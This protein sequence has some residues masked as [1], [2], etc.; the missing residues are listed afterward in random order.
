MYPSPLPIPSYYHHTFYF[1]KT[2]SPF[3]NWER[4]NLQWSKMLSILTEFRT[5]KNRSKSS[6]YWTLW[7][8]CSSISRWTLQSS[9]ERIRLKQHT[10]QL[11]F[12][13]IKFVYYRTLNITALLVWRHNPWI[14]RMTSGLLTLSP[15]SPGIPFIP[16]KPGYPC[17]KSESSNYRFKTYHFRTRQ[18]YT[19]LCASNPL[20]QIFSSRFYF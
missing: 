5:K 19:F 1:W 7:T 8:L 2:N 11:L 3:C 14:T 17:N 10:N 4:I 18:L 9:Q 12:I 13:S 6:Y 16:G 15:P 20:N